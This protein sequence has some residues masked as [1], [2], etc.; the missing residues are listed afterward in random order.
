MPNDFRHPKSSSATGAS[1]DPLRTVL[2]STFESLRLQISK[3]SLRPVDLHD[4]LP[5]ADVQSWRREIH[6]SLDDP[7]FPPHLTAL[8]GEGLMRSRRVL[9][10]DP[11]A[12]FAYLSCVDEL[13][14]H[15]DC[16]RLPSPVASDLAWEVILTLVMILVVLQRA[17]R[18]PAL[19]GL[20]EERLALSSGDCFLQ[21]LIEGVRA[22]DAAQRGDLESA[23][24]WV[25][26][27]RAITQEGG[28]APERLGI[29]SF[30][31]ASIACSS[32]D[33]DLETRAKAGVRRLLASLS[34]VN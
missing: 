4:S 21:G 30:M 8:V 11:A 13:L 2:D 19:L 6:A 20:I 5:L 24:R 26:Q 33:R 15:P 7:A 32:S 23:H 34:V 9:V 28:Y 14:Q 18:L 22:L 17:P 3:A 10:S 29:D 12:A 1:Q 25:E 27:A 31:R 16:R